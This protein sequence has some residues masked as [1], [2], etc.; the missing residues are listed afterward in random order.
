MEIDGLVECHLSLA[1]ECPRCH[2]NIL[3]DGW[4]IVCGFKQE[5]NPSGMTIDGNHLKFVG[6]QI[7]G[8]CKKCM[9]DN[10]LSGNYDYTGV[11][12]IL[13]F[14]EFRRLVSDFII[15]FLIDFRDGE[16]NLPEKDTAPKN[17]Q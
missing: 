15:K 7:F 12:Q 14:D 6:V 17:M 1:H 13:S 9:S 11:A 16:I 10:E 8:R 5:N 3:L 2:N 4:K